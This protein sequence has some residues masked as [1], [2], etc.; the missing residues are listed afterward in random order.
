MA[1]RVRPERKTCA[2]AAPRRSA[3]ERPMPLDAPVTIAVLSFSRLPAL[4]V[5]PPCPTGNLTLFT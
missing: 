5:D 1:S 4:T 2:P 3:I